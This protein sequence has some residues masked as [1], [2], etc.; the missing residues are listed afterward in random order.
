MLVL[1]V[2]EPS[3]LAEPGCVVE[4][5]GLDD[6]CPVPAVVDEVVDGSVDVVVAA[7]PSVG[8]LRPLRA[9]VPLDVAPPPVL[10]VADVP[11]VACDFS[12]IGTL[13]VVVEVV[14][15]VGTAADGVF[16]TG[17][18]RGCGCDGCDEAIAG[19]DSSGASALEY[20]TRAAVCRTT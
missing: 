12:L 8:F 2:V 20:T 19:A 15:V 3:G 4:S 10:F 13:T 16:A 17:V 18:I 1:E 7:D 11:P 6:D 5:E 14:T 9:P